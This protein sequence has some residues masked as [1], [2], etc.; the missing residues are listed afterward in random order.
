M[1][2]MIALVLVVLGGTGN[3]VL[4]IL[5]TFSFFQNINRLEHYG[6]DR[7]Q[8]VHLIVVTGDKI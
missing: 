6:I 5:N 1:D 7:T 2:R 8:T 3:T 4:G